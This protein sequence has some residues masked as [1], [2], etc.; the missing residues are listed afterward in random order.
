MPMP[1]PICTLFRAA[2]SSLNRRISSIIWHAA[3]TAPRRWSSRGNGAPKIAI[4][5][6]PTIWFTIP[7]SLPIASIISV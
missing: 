5:P 4:S 1:M 7:P 6:S 2:C 3:S